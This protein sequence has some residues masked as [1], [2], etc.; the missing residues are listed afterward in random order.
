MVWDELLPLLSS[1]ME[2]VKG[3][4]TVQSMGIDSGCMFTKRGIHHCFVRTVQLCG[5]YEVNKC[6]ERVL[7]RMNK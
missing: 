1:G 5:V 2:F 6:T 7:Y 4:T 3:L